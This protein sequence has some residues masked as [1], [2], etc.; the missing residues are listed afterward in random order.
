MS[1]G[2][3]RAIAHRMPSKRVE[4][5][6]FKDHHMPA[7]AGHTAYFSEPI[8]MLGVVNVVK[9][10]RGEHQVKS[11]VRRRQLAIGDQQLRFVAAM[12]PPSRFQA[13]G[14]YIRRGGRDIGKI[15]PE[16]RKRIADPAAE[17]QNLRP[18]QT[19]A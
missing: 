14:R 18:V 19:P 9:H 16:R 13:F 6:M 11:A 3:E 1:I 8:D 2:V 15:P 7:G 4:R 17:I 12:Q 5:I 10:A